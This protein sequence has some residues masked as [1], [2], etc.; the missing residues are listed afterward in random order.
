LCRKELIHL[1][2]TDASARFWESSR[3]DCSEPAGG[4]RPFW[5]DGRPSIASIALPC[6]A[7]EPFSACY[8]RENSLETGLDLGYRISPALENR[9]R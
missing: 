7:A 8:F 6:T 5:V 4:I 3:F 9:A 2:R 1:W